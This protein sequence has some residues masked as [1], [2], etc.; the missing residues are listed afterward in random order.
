MAQ[1]ARAENKFDME[2]YFEFRFIVSLYTKRVGDFVNTVGEIISFRIKKNPVVIEA[3]LYV[4]FSGNPAFRKADKS[5]SL[6]ASFSNV[7]CFV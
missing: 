7:N 5:R 1:T 2:V 6:S 4:D 3:Y